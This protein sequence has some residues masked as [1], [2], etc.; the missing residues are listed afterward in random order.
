METLTLLQVSLCVSYA[1]YVWLC[2]QISWYMILYLP[3]YHMAYLPLYLMAHL[4]L[5][6]MLF[7]CVY[8]VLCVC[9]NLMSNMFVYD[10][11]CICVF[12]SYELLNNASVT[13]HFRRTCY[14]YGY[15]E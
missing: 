15:R 9:V 14:G 3:M 5:Y 8:D 6:S 11:I 7:L 1:L 10:I 13:Y 2:T 4:S 12:A